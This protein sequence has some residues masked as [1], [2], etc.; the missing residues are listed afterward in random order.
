MKISAKCITYGRVQTLEEAL[1]SFLIQ[2]YVG[3]NE[4]IIVNDYP[5]QFLKFDHPRVKIYNCPKTFSTIGEKE[6]YTLERCSGDIIAVWDDDD[7]YLSRHLSNIPKY[8]KEDTNI[9]HWK[10]VYFN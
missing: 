7:I 3:E 5:K 2:D 1:H 4:L 6:N 9:L 8:W 10:G